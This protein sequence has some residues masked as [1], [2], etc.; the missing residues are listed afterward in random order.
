M[1]VRLL[2]INHESWMEMQRRL[3]PRCSNMSTSILYLHHL[4]LSSR[5][6]YGNAFTYVKTY[7]NL[8]QR[9]CHKLQIPES[10]VLFV[11]AMLV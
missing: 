7:L 1:S 10:D 8:K 11:D 9:L 2:T 3:Y 4:I 6:V 5:L